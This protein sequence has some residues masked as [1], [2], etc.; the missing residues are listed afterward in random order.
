[1]VALDINDVQQNHPS[2]NQIPREA[3]LDYVKMH[4]MWPPNSS[5]KVENL[6]FNII[7]SAMMILAAPLLQNH[8]QNNLALC[9]FQSPDRWL[10]LQYRA[11]F[12]LVAYVSDSKLGP[13][14][15]SCMHN[16][17]FAYIE[18]SHSRHSPP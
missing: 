16:H 11:V 3:D 14:R 1:M 2:I 9:I 7:P 13:H 15:L 17:T 5:E 10:S 12:G 4:L 8:R 6:T 18:Y